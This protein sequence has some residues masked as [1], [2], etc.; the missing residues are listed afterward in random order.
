MSYLVVNLVDRFLKA[1]AQ[2]SK[3]ISGHNDNTF[4]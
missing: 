3:K 1:D 2:Q 4:L